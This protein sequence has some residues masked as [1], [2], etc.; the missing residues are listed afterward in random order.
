LPNISVTNDLEYLAL[1]SLVLILPKIFMRFRIPSGITALILGAAAIQ[2]DPNIKTD[3]LF[4]FLS[5]IGITSLFVFAGL[6]VNLKELKDDRVY[7]SK[8]LVQS[9]VALFIIGFGLKSY[10]QLPVQESLLLALGIFTPSA[11]FIINSLHSYDISKDQEH[12]IKSKA[13]SKE[14]IAIVL[15]FLAMQSGNLE[16]MAISIV[17]Y[18]T[19]FVLLPVIFRYFFKFVSPYAPN[20]EVP[21]LVVLSLIS[22]VISKELGAYYLVGAFIVGIIGS[23]FKDEIFKKDQETIFTALSSFFNVFLPFYFFFA[24]TKIPVDKLTMSSLYTAIAL[25]VIFVPL[26]I[27]IIRLN[28]RYL[29]ADFSRKNYNVSLSLMPTLIFG[30]VIAQII[31]DRGNAPVQ[32]VYALIIYTLLTSILPAILISFKD[33]EDPLDP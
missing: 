32:I 18:G 7:L 19:L 29:L 9:L 14:L 24:G 27:I 11:G 1:F 23:Q 5:Q 30:L 8:Y 31:K 17:F 22:G 33:G 28:V 21:L 26:R 10:F 13:I 4:R 2:F 3:Q 16:S 15:L 20:S 25:F 12:W 6:E